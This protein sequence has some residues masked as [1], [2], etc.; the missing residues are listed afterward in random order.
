MK[1]TKKIIVFLT[2]VLL[3]IS[4]SGNNS[5]AEEQT[6][7]VSEPTILATVDI[8]RTSIISQDGNKLKISIDFFNGE[9]IQSGIKYAVELMQNDGQN[10]T[11]VDEKIYDE[12][13]TM[14]PRQIIHRE[15]DYTAPSY[16]KG[17]YQVWVGSQNDKGMPFAGAISGTVTLNGDFQYIGIDSKKCYLKVDGQPDTQYT[18]TQGVDVSSSENLTLTCT[19]KNNFSSS[20]TVTPRFDTYYRTIYG[21]LVSSEKSANIT[22]S[23]G[24][25][26][27]IDFSIP[28]AQK[29]QAYDTVMTLLN[30]GGKEVSDKVTAHYVIQGRSATIQNVRFDKDA[31]FSGETANLIFNWSGNADDFSSARSGSV[32]SSDDILKITIMN[33]GASYCSNPYEKSITAGKMDNVEISVPITADCPYPTASLAIKDE[34]GNILDKTEFD[35]KKPD[36]EVEKNLPSG[37][38]GNG[39]KTRVAIGIVVLLFIVSA[40]LIIKRK[41]AKST[42]YF[43]LVFLGSALFFGSLGSNRAEAATFYLHPVPHHCSENDGASY[44]ANVQH[45]DASDF[46]APDQWRPG[47]R[48]RVSLDP[49]HYPPRISNCDN[50]DWASSLFGAVGHPV[51]SWRPNPVPKGDGDFISYDTPNSDN[52][53]ELWYRSDVGGSS[54]SAHYA[55]N[56]SVGYYDIVA[57]SSNAIYLAGGTFSPLN[58]R[59]GEVDGLDYCHAFLTSKYENASFWYN[60]I[61]YSRI[62]RVAISPNASGRIWSEDGR[63]NCNSNSGF[64]SGC[65]YSSYND[66]NVVRLHADP[67]TDFTAGSWSGSYGCSGSTGNVCSITINRDG[68]ATASFTEKPKLTITVKNPDGHVKDDANGINCS[69]ASGVATCVKYFNSGT[70]VNLKAS[71]F[72]SSHPGDWDQV[73]GDNSTGCKGK[74]PDQNCSF[75]MSGNKNVMMT[76]YSNN[77][78]GPVDPAD[79][80]NCNTTDC[81][82]TCSTEKC[83]STTPSDP[84][85]ICY[86]KKTCS[87]WKEVQP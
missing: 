57:N 50:G 66:G 71:D 16:L 19:L 53:F 40:G 32:D 7:D 85:I 59:D 61:P 74:H 65:F 46:T 42:V 83:D 22:L 1:K 4:F 8:G 29:P 39:T 20:E 73:G 38:A 56:Y 44:Y 15:I 48:I 21:D 12:V 33:N 51:N 47:E 43:F 72:T 68:D 82:N 76:F 67:G 36:G 13:L 52:S 75:T 11:L 55:P 10:V 37:S 60:V 84:T 62:L 34:K 18:L 78:T 9:R 54:G 31:Y 17:E 23:G 70:N 81:D 86:G 64:A 30:S 87:I 49:A 26:K 25:E 28:K 80:G 6:S 41:L 5:R 24:E 27:V 35:L 3:G 63:I 58:Y 14:G 79:P 2:A 69:S 77:N 45:I